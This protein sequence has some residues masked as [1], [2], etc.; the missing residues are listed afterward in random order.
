VGDSDIGVVL[1]T[2]CWGSGDAELELLSVSLAA[3]GLPFSASGLTGDDRTLE[4]FSGSRGSA[5]F[6][7]PT[8]APPSP[9]TEPRLP[10]L[11]ISLPSLTATKPSFLAFSSLLRTTRSCQQSL[12]NM[13]IPAGAVILQTPCTP[14]NKPNADNVINNIMT[15]MKRTVPNTP[16][17]G[18]TRESFGFTFGGFNTLGIRS[19]KIPHRRIGNRT[20]IAATVG[21]ANQAEYCKNVIPNA[22]VKTRFVGFEET[23][24]ALTRFEA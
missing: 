14:S 2:G 22:E 3:D 9:P 13:M 5:I 15:M 11:V 23:S 16:P 8:L 10:T 21:R 1:V 20:I 24:S 12:K 6:P 18:S 7:F 4:G 19:R 17:H